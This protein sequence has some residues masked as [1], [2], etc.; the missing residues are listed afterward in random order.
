MAEDPFHRS[1]REFVVQQRLIE[2]EDRLILAVSGGLDSMVMLDAVAALQ[3]DLRLS[4]IVAHFNHQLRG[5]ESEADEAFVRSTARTMGLECYIEH[6]NTQTAAEASRTSIQEAARNLRYEFFAKLRTS[7]G[8]HKIATAHHADDNAETVLFHLVRGTGVH[9]L[10]GIPLRRA[11]IAV[12]RPLM[13]ATRD[14]I[15]SYAT[16]HGVTYR[17]DSSNLGKDYTRN[18]IR[19]EIMPRIREQINPNVTLTLRRSSEL[20]HHLDEYLQAQANALE[21]TVMLRST[22][23]EIALDRVQL[24]RQ[25][26]F[27]Q[28][29]LLFLAVRKLARMEADFATIRAMMSICLSDTGSSMTITKDIVFFRDREE[30]LL[31]RLKTTMP[32][33]YNVE[34]GR[35]YELEHF[36]FSMA[37]V[38]T[39]EFSNDPNVE[40][41]DADKLV[42]T[43]T[44]RSWADGDSFLPLGMTGMKK[45]SDFFIEQ[46]VPLFEKPTIPLLLHNDSIVWVCGMRLDNRFKV[47]PSTKRIF[48]LE[49]SRR[50]S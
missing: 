12:I 11:D 10:A 38:D 45:L 48:K 42:G 34:P 15:R 43:L 16:E 50:S 29:Y 25:H 1:L 30:V 27:M 3:K 20:F 2:R 32:F 31:R 19:H 6:A 13:F 26:V 47:T 33:R 7:L 41:V 17:T 23:T 8:Y 37:T 49:F 9:G 39:A 21:R 22:G 28:E 44:L 5:H 4:I 46:K 35:L 36:R 40:F 14:E 24:L 18:F